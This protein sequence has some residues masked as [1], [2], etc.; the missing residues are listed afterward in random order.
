MPN[1]KVFI[2]GKH[3]HQEFIRQYP[4]V[5]DGKSQEDKIALLRT[6]INN[7]RNKARANFI[8]RQ[9]VLSNCQ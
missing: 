8:R 3:V 7:E 4:H 1:I 6:K 9:A 2:S 5:L